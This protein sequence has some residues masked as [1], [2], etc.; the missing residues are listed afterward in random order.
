MFEFIF[1]KIF[2]TSNERELRRIQ[3]KVD[4]INSMEPRIRKLSDWELRQ[5]TIE[6]KQK[7]DQGASLD[8]LLIEAFAV[9][10][11]AA[12]RTLNMRHYDVQLIG[13]IVLHEGKIAEMKTGEG[14]TLVAT[15][16]CY[17]NALS[18]KGVHVV[19]V[20][21]YL[22]KRDEEWMGKVYHFLGLTTGVVYP[23]QSESEKKAAYRADITYGQNNEFG[24]DYL[25]DNMKFSIY[26]YVQR[27]LNYAIVDEVDS[28]LID[29]ARTPLIISGEGQPASPKYVQ[30]AELM[31]KLRKDEHYVVDE[32]NHHVSLTDE[33]VE[34]VQNLLYERGIIE[35]MN[36][37]DPS[38][39]ETL[40]ILHQSLKAHALY[41]RDQHY[42]VTSDHRV[43]IID[44]FTGR[45]LPGRRWSDGLHQAIEAKERVP[46]QSESRTLATISF[47]NYFRLYR[48]LAGMTGTAATEAA[49]FIK[50]YGLEV[51]VIP[52]N[53]PVRR[54][55]YDDLI[56]KTERAKFKAVVEHIAECYQ[57]GRPV[58]VG[59]T[60]VEK[61][62][63]LAKML[64]KRGIPYNL[65]NAKHHERE[66][67]I[68]AQAGRKGA[69]T[70]ATNMAGRGTDILLGGNPEMLAKWEVLERARDELKQLQEQANPEDSGEAKQVPLLY[71]K[72]RLE[73]EIQILKQKY[74]SICMKEREEVIKLGGLQVIGTERHESRRIDNQ[75]R[76]RSGRQG[77]PG[78]SRFYISLEDDL[79]RIFGGDRLKQIMDSIGM[80]EDVPIEHPWVTK[81]VEN[82]QKKVEERNFDIRKNLLE[83]D[84][85]LNQQRK[86]IY[87][88]R[89][90]ILEGQYRS[91]PTDEERKKGREPTPLVQEPKK[92]FIE[93]V[94]PI[95]EQ[96]IRFHG[97]PPQPPADST[98]EEKENWIRFIR[99][100]PIEEAKDIRVDALERNVYEVFGCRVSVAPLAS[101]PK[102]LLEHLVHAVALSLTEQNERLLDMIESIILR[103]VEK[104]CPSHIHPSDWNILG[105]KQEY[106][107]IFGI[108]ASVKAYDSMQLAEK[109]YRDAE[110]VIRKK[111][112]EI[113]P[114]FFRMFRNIYLREIDRKWLE[115]LNV[116]EQLREGI[117]LRGYGQRDPKKEYKK[118]GYEL[119]IAMMNTCQEEVCR[120]MFGIRVI[121]E[122][123]I[124]QIEEIRRKEA[125]RQLER[126]HAVHPGEEEESPLPASASTSAPFGDGWAQGRDPKWG[127]RAPS[128]AAGM[129]P[130]T[131]EER[132]RDEA[133]PVPYRRQGPKIGRNDPC[134]CGSGK[135]YK[136]CHLR[137][138]EATPLEKAGQK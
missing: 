83:Y 125:A 63:A 100:G 133:K 124:R 5:K 37:F 85:V 18:G 21:D 1:R 112:E 43:L 66:A 3:P 72:K 102:K 8:D 70:I 32:K 40:H 132:G 64:D 111:Q 34:F 94:R 136:H 29:E 105:L 129:L 116:I 81:T 67:Y 127:G 28:I 11:E 99:F 61:S 60:S 35:V 50:I 17:L 9:C 15:L 62:E 138:D 7:I 113:G 80:E 79:M 68:I 53:K 126:L 47:Q 89:R 69:V 76:G 31:P 110:A 75:L 101:D 51:V 30:I 117:G 77:D 91:V 26:D 10:R 20:N 130:R 56:F 55:D 48:K 25:R 88:L 123:D 4:A 115:H 93:Q 38:N 87:T 119:F 84:D 36:L 122:E 12:R 98:R 103:I 118:E 74:E 41:K 109:L 97:A 39:I 14:K 71:D 58:L 95:L 24:F 44:E 59:T 22:A 19:T 42:L 134:W 120:Q 33:G 86:T 57:S 73:E 90:Q 135:K 104:N 46:I 78:A 128:Q 92:E 52:T 96:M 137:L 65:L 106:K 2:G 23:Q 131:S 82:T 121:R 13:G 54:I 6:F 108:E 16:P 107:R 45:I 49:E 114:D 27:D